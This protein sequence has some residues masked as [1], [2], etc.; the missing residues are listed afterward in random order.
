MRR[1]TNQFYQ[2]PTL[3]CAVL[4]IFREY[5]LDIT[6]VYDIVYENDVKL[7]NWSYKGKSGI[8]NE[9]NVS[10]GAFL[11]EK[12]G[13]NTG[14]WRRIEK[15]HDYRAENFTT[16]MTGASKEKLAEIRPKSTD[17]AVNIPN[18]PRKR[19]ISKY[20]CEELTLE[21]VA[22]KTHT[23]I[24]VIT[25]CTNVCYRHHVP[26]KILI[27][28]GELVCIGSGE[29]LASSLLKDA[30]CEP[31]GKIY[32]SSW[33]KRN[34]ELDY[35]I[36]PNNVVYVDTPNGHLRTHNVDIPGDNVE[37]AP[38]SA[39]I[40]EYRER[41]QS[42]IGWHNYWLPANNDELFRIPATATA[43]TVDLE[44]NRTVV[45]H[46]RTSFVMV[47]PIIADE[48]LEV[49]Y[50]GKNDEFY[51]KTADD[52]ESYV[53]LKRY[54]AEKSGMHVK[55]T[56]IPSRMT[57]AY[58]KALEKSGDKGVWDRRRAKYENRGMDE[59]GHKC[60]IDGKHLTHRKVIAPKSYFC[61]SIYGGVGVW[62]KDLRAC[63][64]HVKTDVETIRHRDNAK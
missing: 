24:G 2:H 36:D 46:E 33:F 60:F 6:V 26:T 51:A 9:F 54:V 43:A 55:N 22:P 13:Y 64:I 37:D 35:R 10:L 14:N 47:D 53:L 52:E 18:F 41:S 5:L 7:Y 25:I 4:H 63:A 58:A 45:C 17:R 44:G 50:N 61:T 48:I 34:N 15:N 21:V 49:Y 62:V 8:F 39:V 40:F 59:K 16:K 27:K 11:A 3:N 57:K 28:D 19:W 38:T 12:L 23:A 31:H 1:H 29:T 30:G 56:Y 32:H 42:T 20:T